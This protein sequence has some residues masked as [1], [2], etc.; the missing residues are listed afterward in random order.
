M[1]VIEVKKDDKAIAAAPDKKALKA[2]DPI[3]DSYN[4][5]GLFGVGPG[6]I[7]EPANAHEAV[8]L[9]IANRALGKDN[10]ER[11]AF[12]IRRFTRAQ[13]KEIADFVE[14]MLTTRKLRDEDEYLSYKAVI[15]AI[16]KRWFFGREVKRMRELLVILGDEAQKREKMRLAIVQAADVIH[17]QYQSCRYSA[18][19]HREC[20]RAIKSLTRITTLVTKCGALQELR[21][22]EEF[23][24]LVA[25]VGRCRKEEA[26]LM[27]KTVHE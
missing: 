11:I 16:E 2:L 24:Q 13:I 8:A 14:V 25:Q 9:A 1:P 7:K 27:I 26:S 3:L 19:H 12:N 5:E 15:G 21:E 20:K 23:N 4:R 22:N 17:D 6:A 10:A 18:K